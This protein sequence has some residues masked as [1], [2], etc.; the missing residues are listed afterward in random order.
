MKNIGKFRNLFIFLKTSP[1]IIGEKLHYFLHLL[2]VRALISCLNTGY[3]SFTVNSMH[4]SLLEEIYNGYFTNYV[5]M[6]NNI[7]LQI[8]FL[9]IICYLLYFRD[10]VFFFVSGSSRQQSVTTDPFRIRLICDAN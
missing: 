1:E 2:M 8:F 3:T 7:L 10:I 6:L 5:I 9:K 4:T